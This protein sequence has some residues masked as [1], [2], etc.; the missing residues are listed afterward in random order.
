MNKAT[1]STQNESGFNFGLNPLAQPGFYPNNS[2]YE[3]KLNNAVDLLEIG[4]WEFDP[5]LN[6][7]LLTS[8]YAN[9]LQMN[10]S[11]LK[12]IDTYTFLNTLVHKDDLKSVL[13]VLT[14]LNNKTDGKFEFTI[15]VKTGND[16]Y[17]WIQHIIKLSNKNSKGIGI[18]YSGIAKDVTEFV[19]LNHNLTELEDSLKQADIKYTER[20]KEQ[21]LLYNLF[22]VFNKHRNIN[23]VLTQIAKLV[24]TGCHVE[25]KV[26]ARI[27]Y[28]N[29]SFLSTNFN[30]SEIKINS[31]FSTLSGFHGN[32]EVFYESA[33]DNGNIGPFVQESRNLIEAISFM[34]KSWLD[35]RETEKELENM[36]VELECK[37]EDRTTELTNAHK[38]LSEAHKDISDSINYAKKIQGAMLPKQEQFNKVFN[39][40]LLFYKPKDIVSGDFYWMYEENNKVFVLTAD[41][42]G[43][44]VP[45]AL[46]SMIGIQ[47]L[48]FIIIDKKIEEPDL[49]LNEL[50]ASINK[51][52]N[53]TDSKMRDGMAISLCVIDKTNNTISFAGAQNNAYILRNNEI[54]TLEVDRMPIGGGESDCVK[55]FNKLV[56]P[57]YDNDRIYMFTDGL[58]DQFG[59]EKGKKLMKKNLLKFI[60]T[61][62][63]ESFLDQ[64]KN[65]EQF[66]ETWKGD[67]FQVDDITVIGMKL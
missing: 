52:F 48:D 54:I 23:T 42:T 39:E 28:K 49:I 67:N 43:H 11:V 53:K 7:I 56:L 65:F 35:K 14:M 36:L 17:K 55:S 6:K 45:G 57:Y 12:G 50:D 19:T 44:G 5:V 21:E 62:Q 27:T 31:S 41:C 37:I 64:N 66:Y 60:Q 24:P 61:Q 40:S 46:M 63:N 33:S 25:N 51:I 38:K 58:P 10:F 9:L 30:E 20:V 8:S 59:G 4:L 32:I 3:E 16:T 22:G 29:K 1:I 13:N 15:R 34:L 47:L 2:L 18:N 26:S